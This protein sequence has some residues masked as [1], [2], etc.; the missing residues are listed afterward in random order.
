MSDSTHFANSGVEP[1]IPERATKSLDL[2]HRPEGR[3]PRNISF[4]QNRDLV[5]DKNGLLHALFENS[6]RRYGSRIALECKGAVISYEDLE[7][8]ANRLAH[9]LRN[10]G[11]K[12]GDR[13][14]LLLP[15]SLELYTAVLAILK[16]GGSY[17]PLDPSYPEE[18]VRF[19]ASDSEA[20]LLVTSLEFFDLAGTIE[21]P[22][23]FLNEARN[24]IDKQSKKP[25]LLGICPEDE[26]YV[27]YT[28]GSTGKPKGVPVPHGNAYHLV[29]A[30]QQIYRIEPEDRMLQGFSLAFDAS[31]EEIWT[32]FN[33]GATLVAGTPEVM[34]SGPDLGWKLCDLNITVLSCVPTL[35]AMLTRPVPSIRLLILGGETLPESFI[36]PWFSPERRI[37]NTYGPT[38]TTVVATLSLCRSAQKV[39]IGRPLAN[40]T[41]YIMDENGAILEQGREGELVIGGYGVTQGY[42]H[43]DD[44]TRKQFITNT[45]TELT[46]DTSPVLYRTGDLARINEDHNIEYLGRI[47]TQV[48][49]RGFRV[50]LGEIESLLRAI[51]GVRNAVALVHEIE[52][53]PVLAAY[54][55]AEP[56]ARFDESAA[57]SD[58]KQSLPPYMVPAFIEP[59][60]SFPK[61]PSG[62]I[63]RKAFPVPTRKFARVTVKR[64]D[65][66]LKQTIYEKWSRL[67][68]NEDIAEND[69][70]FLDLGGHSLLAAEFVSGMRDDERFTDLSMSDVYAHSSIEDFAAYLE[71]RSTQK[72]DVG[73]IRGEAPFF[74][75]PTWKYRLSA[76]FQAFM[77]YFVIAF[78]ALQWI[79]PFLVYSFLKAY[80]YPFWESLGASFLSLLVV[81][82]AMLLLG[83]ASKWLVLGRL[84]EGDHPIWGS[85]YLRWLFVQRVLHC[86]PIHFLAGTPL[87]ALYLKLLGSRIG[88]GVY[89]ESH[90]IAGLDLLTI[91]N[92]VCINA[93]ANIACYSLEDGFLKVRRIIIGND[94]CIGIRSVVGMD[95]AIGD[96]TVIGDHTCIGSG[97]RLGNHE[98]WSGS[99]AMRGENRSSD[100]GEKGDRV[101]SPIRDTLALAF[102]TACFFILPALSL[103][104]IFPGIIVMYHFDYATEDYAYLLLSPL[105]A[106]IFVVLSALQI[107]ACKWL[108]LGRLKEGVHSIKSGFYLRK[109][110]VDKLMETSLDMLQTLYATLYLNPWYRA[111]GVKVGKHA[112]ISTA[113]FI[114]PDLLHIGEGS[115]I[116]DGAALGPAKVVGGNL[117]LRKTEIGSR[118]FIGNSAYVPVGARV[119][120]NC[121]L[122]CQTSPPGEV[123]PDGTSW[124]GTP[125]VYLPQRQ[126]PEHQF[127]EE[128]TYHPTRLLYG[129]R[130]FIEFFRVILPATAFVVFATLMLSFSI[131]M[132][133]IYG[134][135]ITVLSFPVLYSLFGVASIVLTVVM[136]QLIVGRYKPDEQPLWSPFVW[137]TELMTGFCENF[138]DEF[139]TQH[140]QGT[141]FLP[142][143]FRRL[144]MRIGRRACLMTMDFTEFDLVRLG[145][146]V[147][148]NEDCTIQTHLFED[149]VMKMSTVDIGSRVSIGTY[150][151]ILYGTVVEDDVKV[152]D[153]SLLMKGERLYRGSQWAGAPVQRHRGL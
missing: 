71:T 59:M 77:M 83:I 8:Q 41:A 42:L 130:L 28:S 19:I 24:D 65:S 111:L 66:P 10:S 102:Y 38:E 70:F 14:C 132:E 40:Y 86:V 120:S 145:D 33:A 138:T 93:D 61:L 30:E 82:P 107:L 69:D 49:I 29:L 117:I 122:G 16:A 17:V 4:L 114:L 121:L 62:K 131:Q 115:F 148:L 68:G 129:Q 45:H 85:Y 3:P 87:L 39:T 116:A 118:S 151:V 1:E 94:V 84:K 106:V 96:G 51:P 144:G 125:A 103:L 105:V 22:K 124:V 73:E 142:W 119:G 25:L 152:G 104:P 37:Y 92:R 9:F 50:E 34:H 60:D 6:A 149:R 126:K 100:D 136:K 128:R 52:G 47:D 46:G 110:V 23:L 11:V 137:R 7:A 36:E 80:G 26:A 12:N 108:F 35:L 20:V 146:D 89:I 91:G 88:K 13:L 31:I 57:I 135:T 5:I 139:F 56:G 63:D 109:W 76:F 127:A 140:L 147:A 18:R 27:I 74:H 15:K 98:Y 32:T 101:E 113:A 54:V 67:F 153:L 134:P 55:L 2:R 79:T 99:P 21:I 75:I 58:L 123:T 64:L 90:L 133:N 44:L 112:E 78:F 97:Q 141:V 72:T 81:Y 43:R 95:V 53:R 150:T 48:K 143:Y